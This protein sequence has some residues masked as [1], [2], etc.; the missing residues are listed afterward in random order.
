M[1]NWTRDWMVNEPKSSAPL[2]QTQ[3]TWLFDLFSFTN[4][5]WHPNLSFSHPPWRKRLLVT[6]Y[7]DLTAMVGQSYPCWALPLILVQCVSCQASVLGCSASDICTS[8]AL[9]LHQVLWRAQHR[10]G[11][12]LQTH[13]NKRS[14]TFTEKGKRGMTQISLL[15]ISHHCFPLSLWQQPLWPCLHLVSKCILWGQIASGLRDLLSLMRI[16]SCKKSSQ[17]LSRNW[18]FPPCPSPCLILAWR[19]LQSIHHVR[20]QQLNLCQSQSQSQRTDSCGVCASLALLP[21]GRF[22]NTLTKWE[23][24]YFCQ[25]CPLR[26]VICLCYT[27]F[28]PR[29]KGAVLN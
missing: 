10:P 13:P 7:A 21:R 1:G 25:T 11:L 14:S 19:F 8:A 28:V 29:D 27:D 3:K 22:S 17:I 23:T 5:K 12:H 15:F 16:F 18:C 6:I 4:I 20:S 9:M 2:F 26:E 24:D